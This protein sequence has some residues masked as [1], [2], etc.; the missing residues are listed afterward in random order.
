[1]KTNTMKALESMMTGVF[2]FPLSLLFTFSHIY[3]SPVFLFR[4]FPL[5]LGEY[6]LFIT[7]FTRPSFE[8][9]D[10][11]VQFFEER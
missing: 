10:S 8:D 3:S 5:F 4:F 2:N 9:I 6:V 11:V 1:M 7:D